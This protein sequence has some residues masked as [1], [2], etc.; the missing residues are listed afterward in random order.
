VLYIYEYELR[1][2]VCSFLFNFRVVLSVSSTITTIT[3]NIFL[4][5]LVLPS[6]NDYLALES[7]S[8]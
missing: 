2:S 3:E 6:S 4:L 1:V 7:G 8:H 5:Y